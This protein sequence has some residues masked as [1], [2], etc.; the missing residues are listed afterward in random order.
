MTTVQVAGRTIGP[1]HPCFIIA[2]AGVNHNGDID[3]AKRLVE[4]ASAAGADAVKFQSFVADELVSNCAPKADY[5]MQTTTSDE[6]QLEML[7]RLELSKTAHFRLR[8]YCHKQGILFLSTPFDAPSVELLQELEVP[9]FK[10]ASPDLTN[11]VLLKH[12]AGTGKPMFVSTG[13]SYLEEVSDAVATIRQTGNEQIVLLHCVS[14]YPAAASDVNL[15]AIESMSETFDV[16]VGYSDHTLGLAVP[17]A[18]T[19]LGACVIEKHFTL[20]KSMTGPDH[21]ASLA[22]KEME[23]MVR[24][25]RTVEEALGNGVKQPCASETNTRLTMR[26]SLAAAASI[27]AGSVIQAR[28]LTALR[29]GTGIPPNMLEGVAGHKAKVAIPRGQLIS[30]QDIE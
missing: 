4:V 6:S 9:A 26:R 29:P 14:N 11:P 5:Q 15:R 25:I 10:V 27:P 20:D 24:G 21:L 8:D 23:S 1:G 28:M 12:I 17:L 13:M 2:E 16:P 19:A 18:A 22:P 30:W 7:Q 3:I